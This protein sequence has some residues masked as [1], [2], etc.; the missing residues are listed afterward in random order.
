[1]AYKDKNPEDLLDFHYDH[2]VPG[3]KSGVD[4]GT[5]DFSVTPLKKNKST[6]AESAKT[7]RGLDE[8]FDSY[9]ELKRYE[10]IREQ[11]KD[12]ARYSGSYSSNDQHGGY[13]AFGEH[14]RTNDS[15]RGFS[16]DSIFAEYD[17]ARSEETGHLEEAPEYEEP[18]SESELAAI[19]RERQR[20]DK[21]Y[22]SVY[23]KNVKKRQGKVPASRFNKLLTAIYVIALA[24]FAISMTV[25]NILP[26]GILIAM[27]VVLGLLS[28]I[29]LLQRRR[30]GV[31]TWSRR[32]GTLLTVLLIAVYGIGTAYA[33]GTLSFLSKTSVD[34]K[35]S[36]NDITKEPFNVVISGMDV[37]GSIDKQGR[38]DV[39]MLLTVN[40]VTA[41]VLMT[42]VPRD[43]EIYMPDKNY[44]MDKLTH[45]GFYSMDTT[46]KAE[47]ELFGVTAN[48]YVKVNFTT[49]EKFVD[50]IGGVDVN[51]E[52]EFVPVKMK[53]WTVQKGVNHMDGAKALAFA[54]ERKAFFDGDR[55]RIKNQQAVLDAML[56]KAMS[57]RT[58]LLN[59]SKILANTGDY[60]EMSFSSSELR[61][62]VK[63][64]LLKRPDWE[65][66]KN[67]VTGG[68][69]SL[70]TFTTGNSRCYVMTQ[71]ET[72]IENA[73]TLINAVM[74]GQTLKKGEND[75]VYVAEGE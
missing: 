48:Y 11:S 17:R 45:T 14:V 44:A 41:Q 47:E 67:S 70:P 18:R 12:A 72:S 16:D 6:N 30:S 2:P 46:I 60:I 34:N 1:M 21:R 23:E 33:V 4:D 5:I 3:R 51:S 53:D 39:N 13:S 63:M 32:L 52:Y 50:A 64:Q 22:R 8:S 61:K 54:R 71:D 74:N 26:S 10:E 56:K 35:M 31:K 20:A 36:V 28:L 19:R 73:R 43:Y 37:S 75:T 57:S 42:S 40:P 58:I 25:M 7:R 62:L 38:S 59:Y 55:Q 9:D 65:T 66:F 29:L 68:D 15:V 27:Y 24:A 69:G 49:V